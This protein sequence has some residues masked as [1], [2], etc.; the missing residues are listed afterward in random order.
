VGRGNVEKV[1]R[2]KFL[3]WKKKDCGEFGC[4]E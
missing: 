1:V 4:V 2:K 3:M